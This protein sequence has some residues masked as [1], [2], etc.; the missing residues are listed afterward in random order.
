MS[1]RY[2]S[3]LI[4]GLLATGFSAH[5]GPLPVGS[6]IQECP[7]VTAEAGAI[8]QS[9]IEVESI[10]KSH[11]GAIFTRDTSVPALGEAYRDPSGLIWG[12]IVTVRDDENKMSQYY[13]GTQY[14]ADNYCKNRGARLPTKT[15]FEKLAKYLGDGTPQGYSPFIAGTYTDILPGLFSHSFW[16][17]SLNPFKAYEAY[18]FSGYGG[19][20]D[21]DGRY[22]NGD[23]M[24]VAGR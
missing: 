3:V 16:S 5:A 14:F 19:F 1:K 22:D 24:C 21:I 12:G 9:G 10:R 15:E 17:S 23:F 11:T 13:P 4:F 18:Y 7:A 2:L 20:V 6:N 8:L